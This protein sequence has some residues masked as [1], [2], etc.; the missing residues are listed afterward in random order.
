MG[1]RRD[2]QCRERPGRG[3]ER[4]P[5]PA[6]LQRELLSGSVS[7]SLPAPG[8]ASLGRGCPSRC[9]SAWV[10]VSHRGSL[11]ICKVV[12]TGMHVH[13]GA[14]FT[15]PGRGVGGSGP[16]AEA[17]LLHDSG[18]VI[19]RLSIPTHKAAPL[20]RLATPWSWALLGP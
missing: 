3:C 8:R 18:G 12:V 9:V 1:T 5:P 2:E 10:I 11:D 17:R 16:V 4:K 7:V 13:S 6:P 14:L 19:P 20:P 15:P